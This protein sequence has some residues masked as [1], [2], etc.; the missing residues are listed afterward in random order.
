MNFLAHLF[1]SGSDPGIRAGNL[2]GD[3]IKGRD[4]SYLPVKVEIGV[5]LH[6]FIDDH[7]DNHEVN[8]RIKKILYPYFHKYAGVA[9]DIYYDHFLAK[10][11]ASYSEEGL[12]NFSQTI[13]S[14]LP[15]YLD[16]FSEKSHRLFAAMT[17]GDWLSGYGTIDGMR[18]TFAGMSRMLPVESGMENA[19][20]I[21]EKHYLGLE[22]GFRE[23]FVSLTTDTEKKL[24]DL[25]RIE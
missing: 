8:L 13:Y 22:E 16:L 7:A 12:A 9:L 20:E 19:V 24:L 21:L 15:S 17:R 10:N 3:E 6:R 5:Y 18:Q 11:W 1:L 14:S 2:F 23:Y 25:L 4:F